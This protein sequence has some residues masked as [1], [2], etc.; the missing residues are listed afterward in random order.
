MNCS[1]S[2]TQTFTFFK[3]RPFMMLRLL[4][5]LTAKLFPHPAMTQWQQMESV[6]H[7]GDQGSRG[8]GGPAIGQS[9]TNMRIVIALLCASCCFGQ[10][11]G[12]AAATGIGGDSALKRKATPRTLSA[13]ALDRWPARDAWDVPGFAALASGNVRAATAGIIDLGGLG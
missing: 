10:G 3:S 11:Q 5:R 1:L 2:V 6:S 7:A 13:L 12:N 8:S 9:E 4:S